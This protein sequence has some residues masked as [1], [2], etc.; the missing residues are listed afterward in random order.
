MHGPRPT[1]QALAMNHTI[2]GTIAQ[3]AQLELARGEHVWCANGSLVSYTPGTSW[4]LRVPGGVGGAVRR[5][6]AGEGMS[7]TFVEGEADGQRVLLGSNHPGQISE[8]NLDQEGPLIATR[9][10]FIA[11]WGVDLDITVTIARRVGAAF[12]GGAGL[13][14]QRVNG[15]G[16]ALVHASGDLVR[17]PLAR[18]ERLLVSTGNL[19]AFSASCDYSIQGVGGCLKMLFGREGMFMTR[20]EGPGMVYLQTLKRGFAARA[21]AHG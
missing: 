8:W 17:R 7:L 21:A 4:R 5:G 1:S 18:G 15:R 14:L 10:S 3:V 11:A 16:T 19:A 20:L 13:F 2:L 6:L 12:F 9:G